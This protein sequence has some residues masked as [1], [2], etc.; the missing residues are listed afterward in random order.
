MTKAFERPI[1]NVMTYENENKEWQKTST[2]SCRSG[3]VFSKLVDEIR[4]EWS[5][6]Q[7][8]A[9][10]MA[11]AFLTAYLRAHR[12]GFTE[13]GQG[14]SDELWPLMLEIGTEETRLNTEELFEDLKMPA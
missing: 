2:F 6:N 13:G 10:Y 11:L 3:P 14:L 8:A 5:I 9:I 12:K 1:I 7:T 4:R